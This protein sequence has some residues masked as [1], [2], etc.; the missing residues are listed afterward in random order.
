MGSL[1]DI[2]GAPRS[3]A[4]AGKNV[5]V[6]GLSAKS[7]ATLMQRFPAFRDIVLGKGLDLTP[8]LIGEIGPEVTAAIIAHG[9]NAPGEQGEA[10]AAS[11][12][13]GSQIDLLAEILVATLPGGAKKAFDRLAAAAGVVGLS[14]TPSPQP[15]DT[16][17]QEATG[18][19]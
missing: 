3:V 6:F 5:D 15:S 14:Q 19:P 17:S 9:C 12:P 2:A 7:I 8:E 4:V 11:L 18:Q 10:A 1:L 16:S 13:I